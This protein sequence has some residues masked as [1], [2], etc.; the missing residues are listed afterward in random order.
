MEIL[1][2]LAGAGAVYYVLEEFYRRSWFKGVSADIRFSTDHVTAGD[3][4]NLIEVITNRKWLP[5]HF[6]NVKFQI[7]RNLKFDGTDTNSQV[8]DH[9]YK[10]DVFSLLFYQKVTRTIPV[11]CTKRGY[12]SVNKMDIISKGLFMNDILV[13]TS[14]LESELMVFPRPV[15]ATVIDVLFRKIMGAIL[16]NQ[17]SYEDPFE[18]RGIRDY[19]T[20]DTMDKINWKA[21]AKA[22]ELKVNLYDYTASQEVC[23]LLNLEPDKVV[24]YEDLLEE[25]I[26]IAGSLIQMLIEHKIATGIISNGKDTITDASILFNSGI[27][28]EHMNAMNVSL[29]GLDL[30]KQME[31]FS[32]LAAEQ[33]AGQYG[34]IL[35]I[36]ISSSKNNRIQEFYNQLCQNQSGAIWILPHH[37]E[38]DWTP[39]DCDPA[40]IISWEV[41]YYD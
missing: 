8:S 27:G 2:M 38:I 24:I 32:E 29:A 34:K 39:K 35:Y 41:P 25:S 40:D 28:L 1:L 23:I 6:V 36:L 15:D 11:I 3:T 9:A 21:T 17:H 7:D 19:Q 22:C 13:K 14:N 18:F 20:Y 10:N 16:S 37:D 5:L 12:Y 33:M 31:D 26:S 4:V 30:N